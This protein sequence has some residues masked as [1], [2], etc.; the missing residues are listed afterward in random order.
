LHD[1]ANDPKDI[2]I[3]EGARHYDVYE[4]EFFKQSCGAAVEWYKK[5]L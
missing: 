1:K 3:I 4:G 2:L 5:H